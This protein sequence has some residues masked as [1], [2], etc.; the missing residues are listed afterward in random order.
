MPNFQ[1]VTF[2]QARQ[3][4]AARLADPNNVYWT[5]AENKL[6]IYEALRTFNALTEIWNEPFAFTATNAG[7]WYDTS[8][9]NGSPRLRTVV[10][11]DL[12][13]IMEYHLLEPPTGA[14]WTG[15]SQFS[16]SDL[17]GA[18][19]RRRDEIIQYAGCNLQNLPF[20]AAAPQ[21]RSLVFPDSTLEPRRVRFFPNSGYGTPVTM[22]REDTLTFDRFSPS[23][24][25]TH[26]IPGHWSVITGAPL[27]M[28]VDA[29]PNVPGDYD[30]IAL[31]CGIPF[32]PPAS[33]P[34][35]IPNDWVWLAKWGAL[36]DLLGRESEATDRQRA[37]YCLKRYTDG[38]KIMQASNWLVSGTIGGSPADTVPLAEMDCFSPEWQNNATAWPTLVIAGMDLVGVCPTPATTTGV[39]VVVVGN[40]PL[41]TADGD[42]VQISRDVLDV[43]LGYAQVLAAFKMG[44]EDFMSTKD[45]EK[46]FF[47]L[48][49]MQNKRLSQMGLFAD[50]VHMEG[51][52]QDVTRPRQ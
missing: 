44:G 35:N 27:E 22:A 51:R 48:C 31:E 23:Y 10:D 3:A 15:T 28:E 52:R 49:V 36:A 14:T 5:D 43:V 13:T 26:A 41:P 8:Q 30:V 19:Q 4:L 29:I 50:T 24:V 47:R 37:D 33:T 16:F 34:M 2:L 17:Q 32:N 25:S 7:T 38:L 42:F 11:T 12:Y 39:S 1:W 45:L 20:L 46:D 18:L 9:M 6:Y 40:T 21:I